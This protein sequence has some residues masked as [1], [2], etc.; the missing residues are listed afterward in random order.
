V[1]ELLELDRRHVW[2]PYG[3]MPGT[4]EP[5]AVVA[6][7]GVRLEL[8]DGRELI[9]GMA[10]WWCAVH[11]YRHPALDAAARDQLGRM[12][13]V[14]FGG[15]THEPAVRLAERLVAMTPAPLEHVFLCDSGSV[16]V[17]VALKLCRQARPGR[18]R[19][20]ALRGGYHGDTWG[21]MSV[22][23]PDGGMH[24]LWEGALSAQVFADRPPV[25]LDDAYAAHLEAL[26]THHAHELAG[27]IVEPVVQ[28]AGGMWFYD[29]AV[30]RLLRELCDA[31]GV[32]LIADEIATG[33]GRSGALFACDHA[34]IA[35]DVMCVGKA[36]TGGYMTL[37]AMLCTGAVAE[38]LEGAP[39][40]HG[41]TYMG[42]PLACAVANASLDALVGWE[43][44][45]ARV[46]EGLRTGLAGVPGARVLGAI[47]VIELDHPVDVAAATAAAVELGVWLRPFR[48]LVYAMPPYV[49]EDGDL[50]RVCAAMVAAARAG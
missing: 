15:L 32:L 4:L 47:G 35:P 26:V 9:D 21:A 42:N 40:M 10:S 28:G 18:H 13:H 12:A 22:C 5:L 27:V 11:G 39:V 16:A 31:H 23:D 34:G 36:L 19:F 29:P 45:V 14:M 41:P 8:A 7:T 3:P 33:F 49:I 30:L 24:A 46:Q 1:Q 37:A 48:N 20:L 38:A 25:A 50:A 44:R 2:H 6:A 43:A 17:E